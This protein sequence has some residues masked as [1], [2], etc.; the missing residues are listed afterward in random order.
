[1]VKLDLRYYILSRS[2]TIS[3][4]RV[5]LS[6]VPVKVIL[7]REFLSL[8]WPR[9]QSDS[10]S[11]ILHLTSTVASLGTFPPVS[12][13]DPRDPHR[14]VSVRDEVSVVND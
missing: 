4:V 1:M 12:S 9:H 8:T 14:F 5:E 11:Q 7:P 13:K 2:I 6:P 3:R 10:G